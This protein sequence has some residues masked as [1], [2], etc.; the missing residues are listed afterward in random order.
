VDKRNESISA[1]QALALLNNGF[2]VSQAK[3]F[4]ERVRR[5]ARESVDAQIE[6]AWRLAIGEDAP[7]ARREALRAFV[8]EHGLENFCRVLINLNEFAFVD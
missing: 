6:R 1:P 2:M 3:H 7:V 5:E 4:A 8:Q